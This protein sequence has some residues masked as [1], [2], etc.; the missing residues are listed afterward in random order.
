MKLL[1][2]WL[3]LAQC[4]E[5]PQYSN[6]DTVFVEGDQLP[7]LWFGGIILG[8]VIY[9]AVYRIKDARKNR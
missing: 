3:I 1:S 4:I 5:R 6:P 7:L 9:W 2:E 8:V